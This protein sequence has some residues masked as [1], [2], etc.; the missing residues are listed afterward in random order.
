MLTVHKM[1][2]NRSK[3]RKKNFNVCLTILWTL[4]V[5]VNFTT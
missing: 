5:R 4:D 3:K 2:N 1:V